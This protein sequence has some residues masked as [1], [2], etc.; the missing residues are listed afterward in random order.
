MTAR[1]VA[2]ADL[3]QDTLH[4]DVDGVLWAVC[5]GSPTGAPDY[6]KELHPGRQRIAME[7]LLCACCKR[8]AARDER[9][10]T[11]I[12]PLLDDATDTIWEGVQTAIPPMCEACAALSPQVCPRLRDG[13]VELRVREAEPIGV[14]GTLYPRP[15]QHHA[16]EPDALVLYD[17]PDL[18]F[19]VARQ[20]VRELRR[21]TVITGALS[22]P[23]HQRLA[24][25]PTKGQ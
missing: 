10:M 5:T 4:R 25:L 8:P 3:E 21:T 18:P 24:G 14:R 22:T 7:N 2:Y 12:M 15:G 20:L 13:H 11:W 17:S 16:P 9:G 1:S 19:V 23:S 6:A